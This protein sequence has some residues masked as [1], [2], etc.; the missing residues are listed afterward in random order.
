MLWP[1]V[2]PPIV[3]P[4]GGLGGGG[5]GVC[6][7]G[8]GGGGL[9]VGGGGLGGGGLGVGGGGLGGGGLGVGGGGLGG[10][11]LGVGGGLGATE[12]VAAVNVPVVHEVFPLT[13]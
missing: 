3:H 8:L 10:G 11:G 5:L 12:H 7:G 4:D 2:T 6:G 1:T 9:G 13:P